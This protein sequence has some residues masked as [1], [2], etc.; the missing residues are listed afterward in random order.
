MPSRHPCKVVK[1]FVFLEHMEYLEL[2]ESRFYTTFSYISLMTYHIWGHSARIYTLVMVIY[3][4]VIIS[5]VPSPTWR[6]QHS[7]FLVDFSKK[8]SKA[9][10]ASPSLKP[11]A[12][13]SHFNKGD[14]ALTKSYL[15]IPKLD[16]CYHCYGSILNA[17]RSKITPY[18]DYCKI[19]SFR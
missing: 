11:T 16:T 4:T 14:R 6:T 1:T 2:L 17:E 12:T 10:C 18:D 3:R 7:T 8:K 5:S 9:C 19:F 15:F 13:I